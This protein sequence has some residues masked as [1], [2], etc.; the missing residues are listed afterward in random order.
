[1]KKFFILFLITSFYNMHPS[2]Y[3]NISLPSD[4]QNLATIVYSSLNEKNEREFTFSCIQDAD[5]R[6]LIISTGYASGTLYKL[7]YHTE[8]EELKT[9]SRI[10]PDSHQNPELNKLLQVVRLK[11]TGRA[12]IQSRAPRVGM[13]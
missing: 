10:L 13:W 9:L 3:N 11:T 2:A 1:M 7:Q 6:K 4:M 12:I 8:N 5:G